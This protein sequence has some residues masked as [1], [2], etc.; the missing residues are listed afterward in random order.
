MRLLNDVRESVCDQSSAVMLSGRELAGTEDN[1]VTRRVRLRV[2]IQRGVDGGRPGM[3]RTFEKLWPNR[4]SMSR[5]SSGSSGLPGSTRMRATLFGTRLM[6]PVGT[7]GCGRTSG[8]ASALAGVVGSAIAGSAARSAFSN[9][10]L[11]ASRRAAASGLGGATE[12]GFCA[13]T[14]WPEPSAGA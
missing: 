11:L 14:S 5:R 4:R 7:V 12:T 13:R 2:D 9:S 1:V 6:S 8:L 3:R 10:S